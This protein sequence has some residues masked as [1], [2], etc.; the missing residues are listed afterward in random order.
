[1]SCLTFETQ[2]F[3]VSSWNHSCR[4]Y[5]I[6][7]WRSWA[8]IWRS[9]NGWA[10]FLFYK[11][12]LNRALLFEWMNENVF[13]WIDNCFALT[14]KIICKWCY[15]EIESKIWYKRCWTKLRILSDFYWI[16]G[17]NDDGKACRFNLALIAKCFNIAIWNLNWCCYWIGWWCTKTQIG[18]A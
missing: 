18:W 1:M 7:W 5:W 15:L 4:N 6:G 2:C 16:S 3:R 8:H 10:T 14:E 11:T 13:I 12:L 9:W 17:E